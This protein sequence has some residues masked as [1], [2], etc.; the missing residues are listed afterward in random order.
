MDVGEADAIGASAATVARRTWRYKHNDIYC[1]WRAVVARRE[2]AEFACSGQGVAEFVPWS[3]VGK[4]PGSALG[5]ARKRLIEAEPTMPQVRTIVYATP[6]LPIPNA[7]LPRVLT[8]PTSDADG[9]LRTAR[10]HDGRQ[11]DEVFH[12]ACSGWVWARE[13]AVAAI[14]RQEGVRRVHVLF[15]LERIDC[16]DGWLGPEARMFY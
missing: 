7:R 1:A 10:V 3:L 6:S 8:M 4:L 9:S 13:Q 12:L 2:V 14:G 11:H 5:A 15:S 16:M